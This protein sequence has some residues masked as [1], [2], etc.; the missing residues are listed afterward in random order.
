SATI[1][2][3]PRPAGNR[4]GHGA[5]ISTGFKCREDMVMIA[6]GT[7]VRRQRLYQAIGRPDIPQDARFATPALCRQNLDALE[8]E[9]GREMLK[10]TAREWEALL[11]PAGV[12][13]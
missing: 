2:D 3:K 12:P 1:G 11:N 13:C 7:E 5:F 8:A 10:K 6:C 9:I 4:N